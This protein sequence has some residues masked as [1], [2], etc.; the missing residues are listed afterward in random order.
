MLNTKLAYFGNVIYKNILNIVMKMKL[1][2][3]YNLSY[4]CYV[5][6]KKQTLRRFSQPFN[7]NRFFNIHFFRFHNVAFFLIRFETSLY[8]SRVQVFFYQTIVLPVQIMV[9]LG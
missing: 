3:L 7:N 8:N 1:N 9:S 4:S 2:K 6:C 5:T